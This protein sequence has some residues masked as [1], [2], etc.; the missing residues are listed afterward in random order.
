[1]ARAFS[2]I[3]VPAAFPKLFVGQRKCQKQKG[4]S[5]TSGLESQQMAYLFSRQIYNKSYRKQ[6]L[7]KYFY[8][9]A[10]VRLFCIYF[11]YSIAAT[12]NNI[13]WKH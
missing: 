6:L 9:L 13:L 8:I 3:H 10:N 2:V 4:F 12:K 7:K 1:M 5:L 11:F